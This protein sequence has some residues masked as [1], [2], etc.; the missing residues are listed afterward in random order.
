M[1]YNLESNFDNFIE[2][3]DLQFS[4]ILTNNKGF[5][6]KNAE[7]LYEIKSVFFNYGIVDGAPKLQTKPIPL[8]KCENNYNKPGAYND[9]KLINSYK[10]AKCLNLKE[11]K[12]SHCMEITNLRNPSAL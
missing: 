7:R 2:F 4:L 8:S 5:E 11:K 12:L 6:I 1:L 3:N 10:T 9:S